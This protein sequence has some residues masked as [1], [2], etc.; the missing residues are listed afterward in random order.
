M[1]QKLALFLA[2]AMAVSLALTGC[3]ANQPANNTDPGSNDL[4]AGSTPAPNDQ[5][6]SGPARTV[7]NWQGFYEPT[8]LDPTY[9]PNAYDYDI[10]YQIYDTLFE[11]DEG[12]YENLRY[13]LCESYEMTEDAMEYTFHIR[14]GVKFHNGDELTAED[15]AFTLERLTTSPTTSSRFGMIKS[16][17][18]VDTYTVTCQMNT[19][20]A[21]LPQLMTA[22]P[23]GIVNKK[24][25]ETY[26]NASPEVAIGT[27]AYQVASWT[28]GQGIVLEAFE[29]Y[30]DG[31]PAI[32][33]VNYTITSDTTAIR[34]KYEAGELDR[35]Y[36]QSADDLTKFGEDPN[37]VAVQYS[38]SSTTNLCFN[39]TRGVLRDA[40]VREAIAYAINTSDLVVLVT[41]GLWKESIS[42]VPT[43][44]QGYSEDVPVRQYDPEKSKALLAEA[45]YNGEPISLMYY[46]NS[47]VSTGVATVIQAY[48]NAVGISVT[49][50]GMET[51]SVTQH[52]ADKDFDMT[53]LELTFGLP[54]SVVT[55]NSL[56]HSE[57]YYNVFC[58]ENAEVDQLIEDAYNTADAAAQ[59]KMLERINYL[60]LEDCLYV[61]LYAG[62]GV[63]F[64]PASLHLNTVNEPA[65]ANIK[66]RYFTWDE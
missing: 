37:S 45:G 5:A 34:V 28:P 11:L 66:I 14:Q 46:S 33:I 7:L 60:A 31:A 55:Y 17:E 12:G 56:W 49:M 18:A 22:C 32:K 19:P 52:I 35:I 65:T 2:L 41:G 9:S 8:T 42:F 48:L 24:A 58:W 3:A 64:H 6:G 30:W 36:A 20:C 59:N 25:I 43:A 44:A 27:G 54:Y 39:T 29:E 50:D 1:K 4:A 38:L 15:V 53:L 62:G 61:P 13:S 47:A 57:G 40:R 63:Y 51:A 26:G 16:A 21:R 23:T 10:I